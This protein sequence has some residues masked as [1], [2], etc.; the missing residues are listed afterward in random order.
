M[1]LDERVVLDALDHGADG[2]LGPFMA[3]NQLGIALQDRS[4]AE[5]V[6]LFDKDGFLAGRCQRMG[7]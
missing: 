2:V 1:H 7:C 4:A 5:A 3:R 6:L